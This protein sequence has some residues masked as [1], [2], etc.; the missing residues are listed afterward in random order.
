M[1]TGKLATLL[2]IAILT[3]SSITMVKAYA[4]STPSVPEFSLKVVAHPFDVAPTTT[5]DPYTGESITTNYGYHDE[6]K[7]IEVTIKNQPFTSTLDA[8]G[9]YTSLYYNVRY[10]GHYTNEWT[11]YGFHNVSNSD[12]TVISIRVNTDG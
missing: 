3:A 12:Y 6:N 1:D 10:K 4:T 8:S 11:L 9:N 7:S 5:I 2:L